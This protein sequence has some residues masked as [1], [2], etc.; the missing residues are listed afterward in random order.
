MQGGDFTRGDGA[1]VTACTLHSSA[2]VLCSVSV[3]VVWQV[4][5][6]AVGFCSRLCAK[7]CQVSKYLSCTDSIKDLVRLSPL[8]FF[9]RPFT[10]RAQPLVG[11]GTGGES[12][13]GRTFKD[14]N[15]TM[16]HDSAG[17]LSMANAGP[18]T[19]GSQFF[20]T[21]VRCPHPLPSTC[22]SENGANHAC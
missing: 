10:I 15:F 11:P 6:R 22:A 1:H 13:Y 2:C 8:I 4:C 17:V 21:F 18:D 19:N 5:C 20:I 14:E 12:I 7:H 9:A 3:N 16:K